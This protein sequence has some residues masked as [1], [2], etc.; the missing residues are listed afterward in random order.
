MNPDI[1]KPLKAY[2][3]HGVPTGGF[4][5]AVLENN[6]M[7]SFGRADIQNRYDLFEICEYVYNK[8][9]M[10]CHGSPEKVKA[11]IDGWAK[12]REKLARHSNCD[13][14]PDGGHSKE[15]LTEN[16]IE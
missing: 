4:L 6:L 10:A 8:M 7:E 14:A 12:H 5:Q 3:E 2:Q 13:G 11:W 15:C 16:G 1:I 9:P